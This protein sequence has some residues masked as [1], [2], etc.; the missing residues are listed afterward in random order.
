[1]IKKQITFSIKDLENISG[2]K[3]HTIRI[4]EKRYNILIPNRTSTNIRLY[5]L[6]NLH[7]LLNVTYLYK[8]GY[9][10][11]K[12][13]N[14]TNNEIK[15]AIKAIASK[16]INKDYFLDELKFSM[17][18]FDQFK[19]NE[20][21]DRLLSETSFREMF[22]DIFIPLTEEIGLQWLS[23]NIT[24]SHEY[25]IKGLIIRK[26][27]ISIEDIKP[28]PSNSDKIYVLFLPDNEVHELGLLYLNYELLKD[29]N[30]TIYLGTSASKES[31]EL[32]VSC[33]D[34]ISFISYFTIAPTK[35][36]VNMFLREI[37]QTILTK[38]DLNLIL[39][40]RNAQ[41]ASFK[42]KHIK[43]FNKIDDLLNKTI[44]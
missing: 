23:E 21:Y 6:D 41:E 43:V 33:Y 2:I 24:P 17:L 44:S 8:S 15:Q 19:F 14:L 42:S 38:Y 16:K 4:W 31:L 11:S 7:K 37:N 22:L 1:L 34:N 36:E 35:I 9:K 40:G 39:L 20:T 5:N 30:Q 3:A 13:G 27:L 26:L 25:F 32:L 18:T 29:G 12:L 28:V 10:I